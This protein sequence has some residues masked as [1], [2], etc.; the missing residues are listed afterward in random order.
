MAAEIRA[1]AKA[2]ED[3]EQERLRK[4]RDAEREAARQQAERYSHV[5]L[6][7]LP[8]VVERGGHDSCGYRGPVTVTAWHF[9]PKARPGAYRMGDSVWGD[10]VCPGCGEEAE[11]ATSRA[12]LFRA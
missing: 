7:E 1:Q 11:V 12:A 5:P 6:D 2:E 9:Q 10:F 8:R 4:E 3:A